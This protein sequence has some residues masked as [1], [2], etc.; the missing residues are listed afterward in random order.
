[1]NIYIW[2]LV[3]HFFYGCTYLFYNVDVSLAKRLAKE[4][5]WI[6]SDSTNRTKELICMLGLVLLFLGMAIIIRGMY[7][8]MDNTYPSPP[9]WY[10]MEGRGV[11]DPQ[12]LDCLFN[13]NTDSVSIIIDFDIFIVKYL[14]TFGRSNINSDDDISFCKNVNGANMCIH[15]FETHSASYIFVTCL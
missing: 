5:V 1:M 15:T 6:Y 13:S 8:W 7:Y 14:W 9:Q 11:S 4:S 10:Y 2:V 3:S 12:Q